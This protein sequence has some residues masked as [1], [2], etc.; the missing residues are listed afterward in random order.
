MRLSTNLVRFHSEFGLKGTLDIFA[1]A[2]F[3][4]IDFN[5]DIEEYHTDVHDKAFYEEIRSYG[6]ERGL[7][8][9]Q[10]H[11]PFGKKYDNIL[12]TPELFENI[13]R[14]MRHASYLGAE[15]IVVHPCRPMDYKADGNREQVFEYNLEFYRRLIP[16]A[17]EFGIKIALENINRSICETAAG[18]VELYDE[19]NHPAFTVCFDVGHGNLIGEDPAEMVYTIGKRIECTHVH[20]NNGV[21]DQHTLPFY[22]NIE[23][24]AVTKALADIGY[25]GNL[26]YEASAF[27]KQL[28]AD[29]MP[30]GAK[31]MAKV[32]QYII[33]RI[34]Y[35]KRVRS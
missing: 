3:E 13:F 32:G 1:E 19:L 29:L 6:E 10:A 34:E 2:G 35:Y 16:Y 27:V 25:E 8:F 17:E 23:W 28:P 22:G 11:A 33:D 20:D 5:T 26:N 4:A 31:F 7:S 21:A 24:Q 18:L 9:S 15:M 12:Q 30:A 14:G